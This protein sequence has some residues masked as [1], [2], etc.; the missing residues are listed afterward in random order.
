MKH[1]SPRYGASLKD[2][3]ERLSIPVPH[4]GCWL[5]L[6]SI[7]SDGYAN[8]GIGGRSIGAHRISW[9]AFRG[10]LLPGDHVLHQCDIPSCVNPDHLFIGSHASNMQDKKEK[11]RAQRLSGSQNGRAVLTPEQVL[12][13]RAAKIGCLRLSRQYGVSTSCIKNIRNGKRWAALGN[14]KPKR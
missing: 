2:R 13:I 8:I 14:E 10:P 4:C 9:L 5:W 7:N 1:L 11:G 6:G 12:E 3:I